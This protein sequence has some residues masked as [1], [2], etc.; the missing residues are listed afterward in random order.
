MQ[1]LSG[2]HFTTLFIDFFVVETKQFVGSLVNNLQKP[3]HEPVCLI[4]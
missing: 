4:E 1:I 2:I 3:V